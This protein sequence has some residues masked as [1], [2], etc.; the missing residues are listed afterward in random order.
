MAKTSGKVPE[1][2]VKETDFMLSTNEDWISSLGQNGAFSKAYTLAIFDFELHFNSTDGTIG[3]IACDDEFINK[4]EDEWNR[5]GLTGKE[6]MAIVC[7]G[8][9]EQRY[10]RQNVEWR[11][12]RLFEGEEYL[13]SDRTDE[14]ESSPTK[15]A[16]TDDD[17]ETQHAVLTDIERPRDE[18]DDEIKT[19]KSGYNII[20][21]I[22]GVCGFTLLVVGCIGLM[23]MGATELDKRYTKDVV[24]NVN[25]KINIDIN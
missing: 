2:R 3:K 7:S 15:Y 20:A 22:I 21:W 5:S 8:C 1:D 23:K 24:D 18:L 25:K 13:R 14:S 9:I 19:E 6:N 17:P 16:P 4:L 11:M 12:I 10:N